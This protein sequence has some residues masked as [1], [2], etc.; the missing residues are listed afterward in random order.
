GRLFKSG[1]LPAAWLCGCGWTGRVKHTLTVP[2]SV[3]ARGVGGTVAHRF[4]A[5]IRW[6]QSLPQTQPSECRDL[7]DRYRCR[8]AADPLSSDCRKHSRRVKY[9]N[10]QNKNSIVGCSDSSD[11]AR[12]MVSVWPIGWPFDLSERG[13]FCSVHRAI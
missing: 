3:A 1:M 6:G 13:Q 7:L 5:V 10:A 4:R 2:T 8:R 12:R 11:L 9:G